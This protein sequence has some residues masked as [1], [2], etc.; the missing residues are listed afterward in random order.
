[1]VA[2]TD[3]TYRVCL[4]LAQLQYDMAHSLQGTGADQ[5]ATVKVQSYKRSSGNRSAWIRGWSLVISI[6]TFMPYLVTFSAIFNEVLP[7]SLTTLL[8]IM[9]GKL[10]LAETP[11]RWRHGI[12]S[13]RRLGLPRHLGLAKDLSRGL[14][15][16]AAVQ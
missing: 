16:L 2:G 6:I 11:L 12:K 7:L 5:H 13:L 14:E 10:P 9:P 8:G 1:M 3:F 15:I 4:V